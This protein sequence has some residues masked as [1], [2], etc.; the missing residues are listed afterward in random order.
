MTAKKTA[1][2]TVAKKAA[3]K[4]IRKKVT[5]VHS[6]AIGRVS[7]ITKKKPT[8]RLV[9]R[10]VKNTE[11]GYFP[12]PITTKLK[13]AV[14]QLKGIERRFVCAVETASNAK[15]IAD[16]LDSHARGGVQFVP[17]PF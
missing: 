14:Y 9:K 8:K 16:V 13:F 15:Q 7:Q 17:G 12:N 3:R 6:K 11:P 10:R 4:T 1:R 5:I 2:K